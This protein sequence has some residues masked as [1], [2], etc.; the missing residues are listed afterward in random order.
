MTSLISIFYSAESVEIL[1]ANCLAP[2][3]NSE[4][5]M[6]LHSTRFYVDDHMGVKKVPSKSKLF[7]EDDVG[8]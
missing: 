2:T 4:I 5:R 1:T 7:T 6:Y 3:V 8:M